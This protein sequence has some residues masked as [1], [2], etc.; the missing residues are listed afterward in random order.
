MKNIRTFILI[1]S[2]IIIVAISCIWNLYVIEKNLDLIVKGQAQSF[3]KQVQT[4]RAW[5]AGHGGVYVPITDETQPN[6]FLDVPNREIYIDSL[7]IALTKVNPAYMTRQIGS[8]AEKENKVKFHITSLDPIRP[9][10]KP[11]KWET[12]QLNKFESGTSEFIEYIEEDSVYRYMAALPIKNACI[13]CHDKQGYKI[14]DIRGGISVTINGANYQES[15]FTQKTSILFFHILIFIAGAVSLLLFQWYSKKQFKKLQGVINQRQQIHNQLAESEEKYRIVA[16]YAH[17]WEYWTNCEGDFVYVS[18]AVERISGYKPDEFYEDN[19]LMEKIIHPDDKRLLLK[20]KHGIIKNRERDPVEFRIITKKDDTN[21]IGHNC[22][23]VYGESG[24]LLGIRGN[25]RL[26]TKR[27]E[28]ERALKES[29]E[30]FRGIVETASDWIW[31]IDKEGKY[32]YSSPKVLS[33]LGYTEKEIIGKNPFDFMPEKEKIRVLEIFNDI[34]TN[35]KTINNVENINTHKNGNLIVLETSGIPFYNAKGEFMGYRGIDR[36]VTKRKETEQALKDSEA[37]L[38]ENNKTKDKFFSILAHDLK[39]PFNSMLGFSDLLANKFDNLSV[40]KQ[41]KFFGVINQG[42]HN[43]Y[44]LIENLLLWSRAQMGTIDFN[45]EKENLYLL[46]RET[47]ELL[48]HTAAEKSIM[49]TNE[50]PEGT[51]ILAERNML[52]TI[53]RNLISNGIKFTP[54]GGTIEI[55]VKSGHALSQYEIYVKDSGIGI[56]KEKIARLFSI[57]ENIST[58]G[59][60]KEEGTGLGLIL[61]KEFVEKHGGEIWVESE[62]GKGSEFIFTIPELKK[63]LLK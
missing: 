32:T 52:L 54:R 24:E 6:P 45:P 63:S 31:E 61:C 36:D 9:Q 28:T 34:V 22:R 46:T 26:I 56:A 53:L 12:V 29:E 44:K 58:K 49:L 48:G 3:F 21:W 41:K 13:K 17:D 55:G 5:N 47:I 39:S 7:G 62:I 16:D 27:K 19:K 10:N 18:P 15:A 43:T 20:H 59:T 37:K 33:I 4:S 50:I 1:I 8:I 30:K 40:E 57:S 51:I 23:D 2:W 60:E 11:D 14:G 35:K 25:N 38:R 42:I